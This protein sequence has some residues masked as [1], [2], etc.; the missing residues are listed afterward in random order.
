LSSLKIFIELTK[1]MNESAQILGLEEL[2]VNDR[3][4]LV[5]L[6]DSCKPGEWETE[7]DYETFSELLLEKFDRT[8]S[9]AQY[10]KSLRILENQ[11]AL[12]RVGSERSQTYQ[13]IDN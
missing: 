10:Y 4:T 6:W 7:L 1:L 11:G 13:L 3:E 5:I 2:S 12:R 8:M 9:R